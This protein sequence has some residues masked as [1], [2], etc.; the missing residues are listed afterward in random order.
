[1]GEHTTPLCSDDMDDPA[2]ADE[3]VRGSL[4]IGELEAMTGMECPVTFRKMLELAAGNR[5]PL[6]MRNGRWGAYRSR[7]PAVATALGMTQESP[8]P[9]AARRSATAT[10]SAAAY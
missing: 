4:V 6:V 10:A 9:R 1:M 3:W 7:L 5:V 8:A 2:R